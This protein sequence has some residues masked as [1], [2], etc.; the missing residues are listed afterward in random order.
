MREQQSKHLFSAACAF[1]SQFGNATIETSPDCS[2]AHFIL[3]Q[4][5]PN[6]ELHAVACVEQC[7]A[8]EGAN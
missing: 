1:L 5:P 6:G 8:G 3:G 4:S 7:R 2:D